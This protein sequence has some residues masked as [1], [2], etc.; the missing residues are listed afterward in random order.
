MNFASPTKREGQAPP[1]QASG[2]TDVKS[3]GAR[4][5]L[6][7]LGFYKAYLSVLFAG[8]CRYEPTCSRYAYEAID[9][10]GV[11]RGGWLGLKRLL[12]CHPLSGRFGYDPVPEKWEEMRANSDVMGKTR[13]VR[14]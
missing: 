8:T 1:L 13:E 10:F 6:F 3:F 5:A 11:L 9:R 2:P 4:A 14:S 7:A 12:R